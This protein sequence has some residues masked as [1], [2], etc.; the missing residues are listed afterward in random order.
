MQ[1]DDVG[2]VGRFQGYVGSGLQSNTVPEV[3]GPSRSFHEGLEVTSNEKPTKAQLNERAARHEADD[4]GAG[5]MHVR[6]TS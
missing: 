3:A 1:G 4:D 6:R 5:V 2:N